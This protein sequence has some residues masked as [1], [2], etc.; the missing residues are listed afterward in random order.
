MSSENRQLPHWTTV[1]SAIQVLMTAFLIYIFY[2]WVNVEEAKEEKWFYF[3]VVN[4]VTVFTIISNIIFPKDN[5]IRHTLA[6]TSLIVFTFILPLTLV[7]IGISSSYSILAG[8]IFT[9]LVICVCPFHVALLAFS[10][11]VAFSYFFP[12]MS[13]ITIDSVYSPFLAY[14]VL[15]AV[16]MIWR[17]LFVKLIL[18]YIHLS[19][20]DPGAEVRTQKKINELEQER[21]ELRNEV[22]THI[23]ELNQAVLSHQPEQQEGQ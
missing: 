2:K 16:A 9:S 15:T 22:M 20:Q 5:F 3:A 6:S 4:G 23:V 12:I 19:T 7:M 11:G 13:N 17:S 18:G 10:T 14:F 8:M 1:F 21:D